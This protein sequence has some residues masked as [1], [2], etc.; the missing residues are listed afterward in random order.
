MKKG[1]SVML[2]I[3][4]LML[5]SIITVGQAAGVISLNNDH[6]SVKLENSGA[7]WKMTELSRLDTSD[8]L[9]IDS[10]EFEILLLD[11]SRFTVNDYEVIGLPQETL[12]NG[13]QV[14]RI[15]YQRKAATSVSAPEFVTVTYELGD[16]PYLHKA[17]DLDAAEGDFID[18]L[19]VFRFSTSQ[20]ASRGG[21]GQPVFIGNWFFGVDY[22]GFYSRHS[23]GFVEPNFRYKHFYKV[24]MEGR[25]DLEFAPRNGLV[26]LFHFPGYARQQVD[27][28]WA[29]MSKRGIVG[30]SATAG[31]NAELGLHDYIAATR[32]PARSNLHYNNW[33]SSEGKA[34]T[35]NNYVD[36]IYQSF[37]DNIAPYGVTLD[38]MVPDH[39]WENTSSFTKIFQPKL[40]SSHE[41]LDVVA[42]AL[43]AKGSNMGIWFTID[44]TNAGYSRGIAIGYQPAVP[45]DYTGWTDYW[46]T[47]NKKWFDILD[48]VY[49]S[50]LKDSLEFLLV[51]AQINYIK[52][53]FNHNFS[54]NYITQRHSREMCLDTTLDLHEYELSL[55]PDLFQNY[56]NGTWFSP[57]WLQHANTIWMM[58]GDSAGGGAWPQVSQKEGATTYRDNWLIQSWNSP[59]RTVRPLIPV[60]NLMTHGIIHSQGKPFSDFKETLEDWTNYV[61]MYYARGTMV[62]EW[63]L[64]PGFLTDDGYEEDDFW[65]GLGTATNWAVEKQG[66]LINTLYVG[67]DPAA[68]KIYGYISWVE[69]RALLIVRN[70]DRAEQTLQVPFDDTVYYRGS[71]GVDYHARI[72]YPFVEQMPLVLTSG[73]NI[74]VT[75]PGDSVM[76]YEIEPGLPVITQT[77]EAAALPAFTSSYTSSKYNITLDVPDEEFLRY[78]I[79]VETWNPSNTLLTINGQTVNPDRGNTVNWS[80]Y[81]YDLRSYRGQTLTISGELTELNSSSAAGS[82]MAVWLIADRQVSSAA[83]PTDEDLPFAWSQHHR[84]LTQN[85][86]ARNTMQIHPAVPNRDP[87]FLSDTLARYDATAGKAYVSVI[88]GSCSDPDMR[89]LTFS[90]ISGPSWLTVKSDGIIGGTPG[91]SDQGLN[92]F[93]VSVVDDSG[94]SDLAVLN[95]AVDPVASDA[96]SFISDPIVAGDATESSPYS[97][98]IAST[99]TDPDGDPLTFSRVSGPAWLNVATD[100]LLSGTPDTGSTGLNTFVVRVTDDN[101]LFDQTTLNIFVINTNDPPVFDLDPISEPNGVEYILYSGTIADDVSDPD[102]GDSLTFSKVS[103]PTWLNVASDG[104]LSGTPD[105]T[106]LGENIFTVRVEDAAG[107]FD[108]A[109]L[110]FEIVVCGSDVEHASFFATDDA[111][112]NNGTTDNKGSL[113]RMPIR[114]GASNCGYIQFNVSDTDNISG[115]KLRIKTRTVGGTNTTVYAVEDNN[116]DEMTINGTNEPAMG[117][118][119]DTVTDLEAYTWYE[120]DVSAFV[121]AE[122]IYSFGIKTT[123][124]GWLD[125]QTK[126]ASGT[127]PELIVEYGGSWNDPPEFNSDIISAGTATEAMLY[128]NSIAAQAYDPDG[129]PLTFNKISGPL[130]LTV[131]G[132]GTISGISGSGD[133]GVNTFVVRVAD[134]NGA[135]DEAQLTITVYAS[136]DIDAD[137]V[138]DVEDFVRLAEEWLNDC[139]DADDWCSGTDLDVSG[140]VGVDDLATFAQSWLEGISVP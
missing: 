116:W 94:S 111:A 107:E 49:Q 138:V 6:I 58:S 59:S 117:D 129:D 65:K 62:K 69:G 80:M 74:A 91:A 84:R 67:G 17:V 118:A 7:V 99:A 128:S 12:E 125:W 101:G 5:L 41:P 103:G 120:F 32:R 52:H 25:D 8:G 27:S 50:D 88:A 77:I 9:V 51:D 102:V 134:D 37:A 20:T 14:V 44:G 137:G 29:V 60:A 26:T 63:Y 121:T 79:A 43:R 54:A 131:A 46:M 31:E 56:T 126:E 42:S 4:V 139:G 82:D 109:T 115:A 15:N 83:A 30:I 85:L 57:W 98:T 135:D 78:D 70:P 28:S 133:P 1:Y 89:S 45:S 64:T 76:I 35:V 16:G 13:K 34:I 61:V 92:T 136:P 23:D 11:D 36:N 3:F 123:Q 68:G 39:G 73:Q 110:S 2:R 97:D 113:N 114:S 24:D 48:P 40:D 112:I 100:G 22:P 90:K 71:T 10:D 132:D 104:V 75:V 106:D 19:Q 66:R 38:S 81:S 108:T 95:I 72:V 18:R 96:P 105:A 119:L 47:G 122:G 53:D 140:T 33:Y 55:N 130:W 124:G 87:Y 93:V 86:I 21:L 127:H